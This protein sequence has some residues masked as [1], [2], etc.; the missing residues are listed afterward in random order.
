MRIENY[1]MTVYIY[2]ILYSLGQPPFFYGQKTFAQTHTDWTKCVPP[3]IALQS[4][5]L[6]LRV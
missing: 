1:L 3:Y 5:S 4:R 2:Y 6:K